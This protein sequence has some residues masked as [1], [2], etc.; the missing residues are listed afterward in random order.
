MRRKLSD[1]CKA[2]SSAA[3]LEVLLLCMAL[4]C[5][6]RTLLPNNKCLTNRGFVQRRILSGLY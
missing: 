2:V 4:S 1:V 6:A 5:M 3:W